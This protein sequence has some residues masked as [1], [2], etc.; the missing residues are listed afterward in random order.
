MGGERQCRIRAAACKR[1]QRN[2][3]QRKAGLCSI[4]K[5]EEN[6][7]EMLKHFISFAIFIVNILKW[8]ARRLCRIILLRFELVTFRVHYGRDRTPSFSW[9]RDCRTCPW[10][11][12][13]ILFFYLWRHQDTPDHVWKDG[14]RENMKICF[15]FLWKSWIWDQ[16]IKLTFSL[17]ISNMGSK[18]EMDILKILNRGSISFQNKQKH[19]M[20]L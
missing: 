18:H 19:E 1:S 9:F 3:T 14:A 8:I 10:L 16:N 11:P 4:G 13:P 7:M 12:K 17:K 15:K 2:G 20:F 5:S 6:H